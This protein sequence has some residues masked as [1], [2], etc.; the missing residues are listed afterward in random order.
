MTIKKRHVFLGHLATYLGGFTVSFAIGTQY[1]ADAFSYQRALGVPLIRV[2]TVALYWPWKWVVWN[3]AYHQYAP[4]VFDM[5]LLLNLVGVAATLVLSFGLAVFRVRRQGISDA[6]GSSRWATDD[7][8]RRAG[9]AANEGVVLAQSS[10]AVFETTFTDT[11]AQ[12][13][14]TKP[15]KFL[16]RHNGPEHVMCFA[17]TRSGKGVGLVIPT[18]TSWK[19]SAIIY[20]IKKELWN[21]TAGWRSQFSH[22]LRFEPSARGSV[23]FNPLLEVRKGDAEV[24]DAQNIAEMLASRGKAD[25]QDDHWSLSA[26][27][28]FTA[29]ILHLLYVG[30]EKHLGG[31]ARLLS[32]PTR[33]LEE[34]FEEMMIA[35][36]LGA[37][38][39]HPVVSQI[40]R[41]FLNK[42]EKERASVV[43]TVMSALSLYRDPIVADNVSASD[44]TINDL[45]NLDNPVSLYLVTPPSDIDRMR[46][47][48]ALLINQIGRR[49]TEK[50]ATDEASKPKHRL[51]MLLDEL[52]SL[53]AMPFLE[54]QLAFLAGYGI[55][56]F[57]IAQSLN[58]L[59][60][61]YGKENSLLDNCH[62]RVTYAANNEETALRVSNQLGQATVKKTSQNVSGA[63]QGIWLQN[64]SESEQEI[65]RSLLT[66]GEVMQLPYD[67]AIVSVAGSPPY[68]AKKVMY[69]QDQRFDGRTAHKAP[70]SPRAQ[71]RELPPPTPNAWFS[72]SSHEE[73]SR[74][75]PDELHGEVS[76]GKPEAS[77]EESLRPSSPPALHAA[78]ADAFSDSETDAVP[79]E[80]PSEAAADSA[81]DVATGESSF[82]GNL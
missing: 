31:L 4:K 16:L 5:A 13:K 40:A 26:R 73:V 50:L 35:N 15:G 41:E 9:L 42:A 29:G 66:A 55:K 2:G 56:V 78:W 17:P 63:R 34:T 21:L 24:R 74:G 49:L 20:D 25:A 23:R 18:L 30:K 79:D 57:L 59:N 27:P 47:L 68:R 60:K 19:Q 14:L 77:A 52:P 82:V 71:R 37:Q 65:G 62:V 1:V 43:S 33:T 70:D 76:R 11:G 45:M 38:G 53:G 81:P 72:G 51:L 75:K 28:L 48:L 10:D 61:V 46:P 64:I 8:V 32:D 6:H 36:H 22:C 80:S 39:P 54:V 69:Y 58:Q 3:L 44:F 7:D 12:W 67:T